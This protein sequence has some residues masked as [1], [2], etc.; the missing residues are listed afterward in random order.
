MTRDALIPRAFC[1]PALPGPALRARASQAR[2]FWA[3]ALWAPALWA[4][5]L[6]APALWAATLLACPAAHAQ[7]VSNVTG[8]LLMS[9]CAAKQPAACDAYVDGFSDAIEAEGHDHALACIPRTSTGTELR[10]VLITYLH[11]HPE[12]QSLKA[13]T[14]AT[15][16][17]AAAYPCRK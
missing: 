14:I 1:A 5:V 8:R 11:S 15:R 7:R 9:A 10:D 17:L 12:A 2:A 4:R 3:G 13:G 16:A 6:W